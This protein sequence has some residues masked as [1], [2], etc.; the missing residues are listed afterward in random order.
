MAQQS[1]KGAKAK[2]APLSPQPTPEEKKTDK[3]YSH[4]A[5]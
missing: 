3:R 5:D 2:P 4:Q 1:S